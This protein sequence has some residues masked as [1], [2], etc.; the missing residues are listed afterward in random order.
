VI[1]AATNRVVRLVN[2]LKRHSGHAGVDQTESESVSLEK[3]FDIKA[4]EAKTAYLL[5]QLEKQGFVVTDDETYGAPPAW[6]LSEKGME[7]LGER[8]RL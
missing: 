3:V 1:P 8:D 6:S 5:R 7:Y 4:S 2:Q